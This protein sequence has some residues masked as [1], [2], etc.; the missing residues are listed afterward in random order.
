MPE[1]WN[2]FSSN[3]GF[4]YHSQVDCKST[5]LG[6]KAKLCSGSE[7]TV[8]KDERTMQNCRCKTVVRIRK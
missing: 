2:R 6:M 3:F 8:L 4:I 1:I 5:K 7:I